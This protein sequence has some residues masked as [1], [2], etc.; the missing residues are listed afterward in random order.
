MN[1]TRHWALYPY[2]EAWDWTP[3][4]TCLI[5]LLDG[6]AD[7]GDVDA[8]FSL[9][10]QPSSMPV[11]DWQSHP[12]S[13]EHYYHLFLEQNSRQKCLTKTSSVPV[14]YSSPRAT[15]RVAIHKRSK[16]ENEGVCPNSTIQKIAHVSYPPHLGNYVSVT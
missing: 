10:K 2:L 13:N 7:V 1:T 3:F 9:F 6:E 5:G 11:T 14:I 8:M 12:L 16:Q 4:R 15:K